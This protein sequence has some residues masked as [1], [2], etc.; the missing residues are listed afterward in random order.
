MHNYLC[1]IPR[2]K[3][4][5]KSI[6]KL[7]NYK[8]SISYKKSGLV[9]IISL[10]SLIALSTHTFAAKLSFDKRT[11]EENDICRKTFPI[12]KETMKETTDALKRDALLNELLE[13]YVQYACYS[14]LKDSLKENDIKEKIKNTYRPLTTMPPE[15]KGYIGFQ[16]HKP[17]A[18][19]KYPEAYW[20]VFDLLFSQIDTEN[21]GYFFH[22]I[23]SGR[24]SRFSIND[25][26]YLAARFYPEKMP[27]NRL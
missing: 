23:N 10:L 7:I 18:N 17:M 16:L 8:R 5:K 15:I 24:H 26:L 4:I 11:P 1:G 27:W 14:N 3:S 12:L 25:K 20:D 6:K 21:Q 19:E 9:I 13:S 2:E 22:F